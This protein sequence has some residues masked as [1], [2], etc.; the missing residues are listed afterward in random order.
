MP[1]S[2][3]VKS[4]PTTIAYLWSGARLHLDRRDILSGC[5]A[6]V[7]QQLPSTEDKVESPFLIFSLSWNI[8]RYT[9]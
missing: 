8:N 7:L 5:A 6:Y 3:A 9:S 2:L 1:S 4:L